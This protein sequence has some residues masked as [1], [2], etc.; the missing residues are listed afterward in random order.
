M[1]YLNWPFMIMVRLK[2]PLRFLVDKNCLQ[3]LDVVRQRKTGSVAEL[4]AL[5]HKKNKRHTQD[6]NHNKR[7]HIQGQAGIA[8]W[9]SSKSRA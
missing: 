1:C 8:R 4:I 2:L 7:H 3:Q 9:S 5:P 6:N